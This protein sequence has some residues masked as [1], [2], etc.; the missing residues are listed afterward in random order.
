ML[1]KLVHITEKN[2]Y[3]CKRTDADYITIYLQ[4]GT[5]V[6]IPQDHET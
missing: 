2:E 1:Y 3:K 5:Q 6:V 4:P